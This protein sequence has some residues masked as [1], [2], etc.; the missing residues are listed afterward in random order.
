LESGASVR[1]LVAGLVFVIAAAAFAGERTPADE[2]AHRTA[3]AEDPAVESMCE[4][5]EPRPLSHIL[6][7]D[8]GYTGVPIHANFA[9]NRSLYWSCEGQH[10]TL[11]GRGVWVLDAG[12]IRITLEHLLRDFRDQGLEPAEDGIEITLGTIYFDESAHFGPRDEAT[13]PEQNGESTQ[14]RA[15]PAWLTDYSLHMNLIGVLGSPSGSPPREDPKPVE[16]FESGALMDSLSPGV[17]ASY[18]GWLLARA[19]ARR[20]KRLREEA[21]QAAEHLRQEAEYAAFIEE[22]MRRLNE[23]NQ[24]AH[25]WPQ[26]EYA[27]HRCGAGA[28]CGVRD[29][30]AGAGDDA[31]VDE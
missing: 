5:P 25:D 1:N 17:R 14:E 19:H 8:G 28:D 11:E 4:Q 22:R 26:F 30:S 10:L 31:E 12:D 23:R 9:P 15:R 3:A 2:D 27:N 20:S 29:F 16:A 7:D 13:V 21:E 6:A 18:E 24:E